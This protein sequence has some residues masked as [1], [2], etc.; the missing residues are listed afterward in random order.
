ML[1]IGKHVAE[2]EGGVAA[3][4]VINAVLEHAWVWQLSL[5]TNK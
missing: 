4:A 5:T 2:D 3:D 1:K